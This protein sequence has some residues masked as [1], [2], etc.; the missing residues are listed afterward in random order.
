MILIINCGSSSLKY[1]L[2]NPDLTEV[3]AKGLIAR[4]GEN[5]SYAEHFVGQERLV[6]RRAIPDHKVGFDVMVDNLLHSELAVIEGPQAITAIGHRA[7]H[8]GDIFVESTLVDE[9]VMEQLHACARFAPLHNPC[10]IAGIEECLRRFPGVPNVVVFDTAFHQSVPREAHVYALPYELYSQWGIRRYGFHGTSCRYVSQ[11]AADILNRPLEDL[12]MVICHLGN[13]VTLD[14]VKAGRSVD[15]SIGFGTFC[16]IP[17]GTRSGDFDPAIIFHLVKERGMSVEEVEALC[18]EKSGLLGVSGVSN[19]M[20][21][22]MERAEAGDDRCALAVDIFVYQIK[23]TVGAYAAAMDGLDALVFTAGI[24]ENSKEI[25][26]RVCAG[27]GVLGVRIDERLNSMVRNGHPNISAADMR[28]ATLVVPTDE[29]RMIALDTYR[30]V[31]DSIRFPAPIT[32][33]APTYAE[34]V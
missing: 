34:R 15:T 23:K 2:Y 6:M 3:V 27:L 31:S 24:G 28:V 21:E 18:Y 1:Q 29:E 12:S 7:V 10:N 33:F 8:G 22:V 16:G 4:I 11:A 14:A 25:R 17:M 9:T 30:L 32:S 13:G 19:D 20:R 26:S 5:G